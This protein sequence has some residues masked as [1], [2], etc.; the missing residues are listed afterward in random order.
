MLSDQRRFFVPCAHCQHEHTL[1]WENVRFQWRLI[2]GGRRALPDEDT[3][4]LHCPKCDKEI[5]EAQ[6]I[7]MVKQ[8]RWIAT[9]PDVKDIAGFQIS[10][11]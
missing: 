9:N 10:R 7:R 4:A 3:A 5:S 2:N 8:G 6:R 11:L 1:E